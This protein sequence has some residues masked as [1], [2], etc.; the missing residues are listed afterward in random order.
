MGIITQIKYKPSWVYELTLK[1]NKDK[2][3]IYVIKND[4]STIGES[5]YLMNYNKIYYTNEQ[6]EKGKV[7]LII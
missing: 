2:N 4:Y 3:I 1:N 5:Q 7:I 6:F